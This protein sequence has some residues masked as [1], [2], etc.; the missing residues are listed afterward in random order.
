MIGDY[1]AA[2]EELARL[3]KAERDAAQSRARVAE[4]LLADVRHAASERL[5]RAEKAESALAQ[6]ERRYL[7]LLSECA[8][9]IRNEPMS[10]RAYTN[11]R[12]LE[13]I[14]SILAAAGA[15]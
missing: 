15:R 7:G 6:A 9:A 3:M 8:A 2:L 10:K 12:L 13:R 11:E 1:A 4:G 14:E 5:A